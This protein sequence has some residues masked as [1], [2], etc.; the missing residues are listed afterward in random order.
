MRILAL[1]PGET[2]GFAVFED[3][4]PTEWGSFDWQDWDK[5]GDLVFPADVVVFERF[6]LFAEKAAVQTGSEFV[7]A[8]VIG[9]I[10]YM[11]HAFGVPTLIMQT[12]NQ[13][14]ANH[15]LTPPMAKL[16][17]PYEPRTGKK[18][19]HARDA[20]AHGFRY[21]QKTATTTTT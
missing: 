16:V 11:V 8:Q 5:L 20:L 9:V 15:K 19:S 3:G 21:L 7:P 13:I 12:P 4:V 10:R 17:D 1:D 6:G 18:Y 14:H 2:T